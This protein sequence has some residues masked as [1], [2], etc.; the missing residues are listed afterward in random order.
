MTPREEMSLI[1][2]MARSLLDDVCNYQN[3]CAEYEEKHESYDYRVYLGGDYSGSKAA[4]Q[5]KIMTMRQELMKLSR[6]L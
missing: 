5:R 2:S 6:A 3:A 1:Y 4:I